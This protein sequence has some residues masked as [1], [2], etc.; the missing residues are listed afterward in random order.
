[1][2]FLQ[3]IIFVNKYVTVITKLSSI[4]TYF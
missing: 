4:F 1:M 3:K 2:V